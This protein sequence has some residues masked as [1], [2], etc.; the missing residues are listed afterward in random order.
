MHIGLVERVVAAGSSGA[1]T[2]DVKNFIVKEC[3]AFVTFWGML[4]P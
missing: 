2:F 1:C 4:T 3:F